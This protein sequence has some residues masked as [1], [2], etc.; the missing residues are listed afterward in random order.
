MICLSWFIPTMPCGN[1]WCGFRIQRKGR[2]IF[3]C[4]GG[5]ADDAQRIIELG[6]YLGI[7]GVVTY[8][9]SGLAS[10]LEQIDLKHIVLETD[11]P[12]LTP[13][14]FRGK[15][16]E[17]SYLS[18]VQE[19]IA[20]IKISAPMKWHPLPPKMLWKYL[21][22]KSSLLITG[23]RVAILR[24]FAV[25]KFSGKT[26]QLAFCLN[27]CAG[28]LFNKSKVLMN[29]QS[30]CR[31]KFEELKACVV[32]P[33]YNNEQTTATVISHVAVYTNHIIVVN[34]GSTDNT[35]SIIASFPAVQSISYPKM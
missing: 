28:F 25:Y 6:Y 11:A 10:V 1:H 5:S 21:H 7:G 17:S 4:F 18:L 35:P 33:T 16:N 26:R 29:G 20:A 23:F 30:I 24:Y 3:H 32:I 12:Y 27:I 9:N 22:F 8:K 14:P 15:R 34:D 2:G 31:Q 19:K 13:V